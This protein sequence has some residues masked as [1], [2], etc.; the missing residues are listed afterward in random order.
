ML[1]RMLASCIL[2]Y[3]FHCTTFEENLSKARLFSVAL[4]IGEMQLIHYITG[5]LLLTKP[6]EIIF[7]CR[8]IGNVMVKTLQ[9][10]TCWLFSSTSTP[11]CFVQSSAQRW[12]NPRKRIVSSCIITNN[13]NICCFFLTTCSFHVHGSYKKL[14]WHCLT[15]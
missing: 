8:D 7:L 1:P 3:Y 12:S 9:G 13:R 6:F 2:V 4:C 15:F 5:H 14:L 11:Y 10:K